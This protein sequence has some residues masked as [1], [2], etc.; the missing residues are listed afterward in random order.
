MAGIAVLFVFVSGAEYGSYAEEN[1]DSG[2]SGRHTAVIEEEE[3]VM[4][5]DSDGVSGSSGTESPAEVVFTDEGFLVSD[6]PGDE[7]IKEDEEN[8]E[9]Q[10]ASSGLSVMIKRY[11][12]EATTGTKT[13]PRIYYVCDIHTTPEVPLTTIVTEGKVPGK[14]LKDPRKLA[15]EHHSVFALTDDFYATRL[16]NSKVYGVIIRNG[17]IIARKTRSS[18]KKRAWPNLDTLAVYGDGSMKTFVSDA[19]TP[20]EYLAD[21]AENV[22]AF[23]PWLVSGGEINPEV[24]DPKYYPYNEP[25]MAIG[26]VEPRHYIVVCAKG[27]PAEQYAGVHLDWLAQK[28]KEY[29]CREAL[30]LDGGDTQEIIFMGKVLNRAGKRMRAVGSMISFGTSDRV[31][32]EEE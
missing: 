26:M 32:A 2:Q 22:F 31:Q 1:S 4:L 30:N 23:G 5:P 18:A 16:R 29:G 3:D 9:W 17:E 7:F 6:V 12:E 11:E 21:G 19:K 20:E 8:G 10:Y 13:K 25:R 15:A 24:L 28:M 27:R 14:A